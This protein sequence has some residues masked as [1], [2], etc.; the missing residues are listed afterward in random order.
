MYSVFF[1]FIKFL[2]CFLVEI[3]FT[4]EPEE[5]TFSSGRIET[6]NIFMQQFG[7]FEVKMNIVNPNCR[8]SAFWLQV[9]KFGEP[10]GDATDG[11]EID[12]MARGA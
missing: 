12:I 11:A 9:P 2:Q 8:H 4:E 1:H 10:T 3:S 6:K 7:V 5:N